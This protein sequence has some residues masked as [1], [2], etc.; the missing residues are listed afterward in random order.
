MLDRHAPILRLRDLSFDEKVGYIL[1]K[2]AG[3]QPPEKL[4]QYAGAIR[5]V[6]LGNQATKLKEAAARHPH[7]PASKHRPS[8]P[9]PE[10]TRAEVEIRIE[11]LNSL[12]QAVSL[13]DPEAGSKYAS[14]GE[15]LARQKEK[16]K[17]WSMA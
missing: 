9:K 6:L 8:T 17:K 3:D 12:I 4:P 1:A 11:Q 10:E 13:N 16:L 14:L 7:V 5:N 2:E 15:K